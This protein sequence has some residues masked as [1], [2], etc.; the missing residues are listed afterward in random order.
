M[1]PTDYGKS[2][3]I[4]IVVVLGLILD[5]NRRFIVVKINDAAA[6]ETSGEICSKLQRAA[7]VLK[8]AE[9]RPLVAWRN[10]NP[11]GIS[12]GFW[13]GGSDRAVGLG[14]NSNRSVHVYA[15]GSR[16]LQGKRGPTLVDDV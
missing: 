8:L 7:D 14:R 11:F 12:N 10:G 16:D 15:L 2:T 3:M 13:V 6:Q 5:H 4:E 1:Y 9:I